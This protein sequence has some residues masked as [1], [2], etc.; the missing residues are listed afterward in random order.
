MDI[1]QQH[2]FTSQ[3][4]PSPAVNTSPC[5]F[6]DFAADGTGQASVLPPDYLQGVME[7]VGVEEHHENGDM[8]RR[9]IAKACDACRRKKIKCDGKQPC[10]S[11]CENYKTDCV[12]THVE[13]KRA[14][15][16]G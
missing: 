5:V 8:K 4:A 1:R 13:K 2:E 9:R 3:V 10:C 11:H 16:K 6:G 12:Y 15:P 7:P 14:P